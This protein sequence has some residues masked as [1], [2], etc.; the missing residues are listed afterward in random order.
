M[1]KINLDALRRSMLTFKEL[2]ADDPDRYHFVDTYCNIMLYNAIINDVH[3]TQEILKYFDRG[4][5]RV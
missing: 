4:T 3:T 2:Y 5:R 1:Y